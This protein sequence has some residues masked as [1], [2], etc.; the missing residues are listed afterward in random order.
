MYFPVS[1]RYRAA[2]GRSQTYAGEI[3]QV[4]TD[5]VTTDLE[6]SDALL[7]TDISI[8]EAGTRGISRT[9]V[10]RGYGGSAMPAQGNRYFDISITA[11]IF[12]QSDA[13]GNFNQ[14]VNRCLFDACPGGV[15]EIAST[16]VFQHIHTRSSI[17]GTSDT[18]LATGTEYKPLTLAVELPN[19]KRRRT[20]DVMLC[21]ANI[22]ATA[23]QIL[24]VTFQGVGRYMPDIPSTLGSPNPP[25]TW[26]RVPKVALGGCFDDGYTSNE[27][28][29]DFG[30][31]FSTGL[32]VKPTNKSCDEFGW[33]PP[34]LSFDSAATLTYAV[35]PDEEYQTALLA[36]TPATLV[37]AEFG[38][39][40]ILFYKI[41]L[42]N[43]ELGDTDGIQTYTITAENVP[44]DT[45][46]T[47]YLQ[48]SPI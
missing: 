2:Y 31:S 10:V 26:L 32:S 3:I 37:S 16:K 19:G 41:A 29:A 48:W 33:G 1:T 11:E 21:I 6:E 18:D 47:W 4:G 20:R 8:S 7:V 45:G 38:S 39:I 15:Q 44:N 14:I 24:T 36:G 13:T 5:P 9:S 43:V 35:M 40:K 12:T 30:F 42:L 34:V 28:K 22:E 46:Q 25:S 23:G 17:T 27:Y